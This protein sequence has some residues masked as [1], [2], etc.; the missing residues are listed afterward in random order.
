VSIDRIPL[1]RSTGALWLCG[2]NDVAP[3]PEAALAWAD[4]AS[5]IVCLN[6]VGELEMRFPGYV[7]WL[8]TNRGGRAIWFPME[9][10]SAPSARMVIPVLAMIRSRLEQGEGV[11][12][13]CAAGQGRAG[14]MAV[15][16]LMALGQ[17]APDAVRTVAANRVFGGPGSA[18][19][20]SLVEGVASELASRDDQSEG[21]SAKGV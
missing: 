19:Q 5:T 14:T 20:W 13:H 18:S 11:V 10:F 21:P 8:R 15:C 12:M 4:S 9:N 2:R 16:V 3:D 1:P 17:S 7:D 6:P